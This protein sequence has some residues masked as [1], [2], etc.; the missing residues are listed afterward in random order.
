MPRKEYDFGIR[1]DAEDLFVVSRLTYKE[2]SERLNVPVVTLKRWGKAGEWKQLK[3][4][5]LLK[6]RSLKQNLALLREK[7]INNAVDQESPDTNDIYAALKIIREE[8]E[9]EQTD[10]PVKVREIDRPKVFLEDM[11]FIVRTLQEID[12][13]GLKILSRNFDRIIAKFKEAH[14]QTA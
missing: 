8:R 2:I 9:F 6:K 11:E 13:E 3:E 7:L 4:D 10:E 14:A 1:M 12:P 5:H